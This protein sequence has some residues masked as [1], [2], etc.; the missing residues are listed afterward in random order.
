MGEQKIFT[1][2]AYFIIFATFMVGGGVAIDHINSQYGVTHTDSDFQ[3]TYG[4]IQ[5]ITNTTD[6]FIGYLNTSANDAN[7][8]SFIRGS[9]GTP[10]KLLTSSFN[11]ISNVIGLFLGTPEDPDSAIPFLGGFGVTLGIALKTIFW[12][13]ITLLF[14]SLVFRWRAA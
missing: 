5:A 2:I 11:Y 10:I 3:D 8:E 13:L 1:Y 4:N 14:V 7:S 9:L 12:T 6:E